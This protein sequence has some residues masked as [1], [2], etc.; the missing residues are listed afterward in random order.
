MSR[1]HASPRLRFFSARLTRIRC[2]SSRSGPSPIHEEA[3]GYR[4]WATPGHRRTLKGARRHADQLGE[5]GAEG[6]QARESDEHADLGHRQ[7][8]R[9][10]EILGSFDTPSGQVVRRRLAIGIL[11]GAG[12]MA[13]RQAAFVG[14]FEDRL[15]F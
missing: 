15:P 12:E 7:V 10:E 8:G 5:A 1:A 2:Q 13:A 3:S 11:E 6:P 14:E 9:P 4:R